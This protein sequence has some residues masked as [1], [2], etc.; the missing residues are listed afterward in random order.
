MLIRSCLDCEF[1]Q[2]KEENGTNIS[3]CGKENCWSRYSKCIAMKALERFL[4]D[5]RTDRRPRSSVL[6]HVYANEE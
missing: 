6:D 5:Q 2:T 4:V 1:H 3:Y